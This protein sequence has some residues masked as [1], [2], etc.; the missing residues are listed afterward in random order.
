MGVR[1]IGNMVSVWLFFVALSFSTT[2]FADKSASALQDVVLV[3][4]RID[5]DSAAM[6]HVIAKEKGYFDA[7]KINLVVRNE[8]D[9]IDTKVS[10]LEQGDVFFM[11]RARVYRVEVDYPGLIKIFNVNT[12]DDTKWNDAILVKKDFN[13][14]SLAQLDTK[15]KFGLLGG[16]PATMPLAR[17]LLKKNNLNA[18]A[19][20]LIDLPIDIPYYTRGLPPGFLDGIKILYA[21]EPFL[22]LFLAKGEW[23]VF[24][25]GPLFS[26]NIFSPWPMTMTLFSTRFLSEKPAL[27]KKVISVYDKVMLFIRENPQEAAAIFSKYL[28][29]EYGLKELNIRLVNYL[30]HDQIGKDLIQRQSDWYFENGLIKSKIDAGDLFFDESAL[31]R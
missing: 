20:K 11:G 13:L 6:L 10:T 14:T 31:K 1:Y 30:K 2:V 29:K 24:M 12:Q 8:F 3:L 17:L 28:E 27:A 26:G 18:E 7:E 9:K 5:G 16:G 15:E 25:D 21:R 4:N 22:S 19:F 23:N